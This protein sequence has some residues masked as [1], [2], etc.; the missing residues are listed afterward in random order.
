MSA[1]IF[2]MLKDPVHLNLISFSFFHFFKEFGAFYCAEGQYS[3]AV[4]DGQIKNMVAPLVWERD[5][6]QTP[7]AIRRLSKII[8][9]DPIY[10][11]AAT[12]AVVVEALR[13]LVGA[14]IELLT[15]KH[16]HIMVRPPGSEPVYWHSGEEPYHPT[17]IKA[18]IYLEESTLENGCMQAVRGGHRGWD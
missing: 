18:L 4:T 3:V 7:A 2:R 5:Q 1:T 11:E 9:R 15:N 10:L 8:E 17:L 12:H 16:N 13:G 6:D 14:H